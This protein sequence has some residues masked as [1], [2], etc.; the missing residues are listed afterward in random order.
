MRRVVIAA[1]DSQRETLSR[2]GGRFEGI[3]VTLTYR[4]GGDYDPRHV[5]EYVRR[6]RYRLQRQGKCFGYQWV[7]E[8]TKRGVPHYHVLWWV[9]KGTRLR[10]PDEA[11]IW[12]HGMSN[13]KRA[14]RP[15]GYLVKYAT[16]GNNG[17]PLPK[18][19][20]LCGVGTADFAVRMAR[21]RYG[22]PVWLFERTDGRCTRVRGGWVAP[23]TGEFFRSPYVLTW[24]HDADGNC[25]GVEIVRHE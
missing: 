11:G 8:T 4:P 12:P 9:P 20:R 18:G 3:L 10:K 14:S 24:R 7:L 25:L 6:E 5:S 22:L 23:D 19:A 21:H 15:V 17:R 16:K 1:A 2:A 13:I